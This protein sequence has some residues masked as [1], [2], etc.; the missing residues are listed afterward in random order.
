MLT[1]EVPTVGPLVKFPGRAGNVDC[2]KQP[3]DAKAV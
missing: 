2:A 1:R 3:I